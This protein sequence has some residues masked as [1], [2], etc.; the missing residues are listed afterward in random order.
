MT[1]D[2]DGAH[3]RDRTADHPTGRTSE[4]EPERTLRGRFRRVVPSVVR[5]NYA[6]RLVV[7]LA[8]VA[9][10]VSAAG[11]AG[12]VQVRNAVEDDRTEMLTEA[13]TLR[14]SSLGEWQSGVRA[15]TRSFSGTLALVDGNGTSVRQSLGRFAATSSANVVEI[16]Y[17]DG[18]GA[19]AVVAA[20]TE[21][22][23]AERSTASMRPAWR[24]AVREARA[25]TDP[26]AVA[27]SAAYER[28]GGQ[29][30]AF[31]SPVADRD[32]VLLVVG[33]VD[34]RRLDSG[35]TGTTAVLDGAGD[36]VFPT[37]ARDT[38]RYAARAGSETARGGETATGEAGDEMLAYAP[39]DGT[40]WVV[41]TAADRATLFGPS[42]VVGRT[43]AAVIALAF[44]SLGVAALVV[45][46]ETVTPLVRLRERIESIEDGDLGADLSTEREDEIGR[47]YDA[48]ADARDALAEQ[49][50][51]AREAREMAEQSKRELERQN[52]RLDQFA[53]TLSHDLRNPLTVARGHLELLSA[54]LT[55]LDG[56]TNRAEL[57]THVEKVEGAHDRIESIIDD[58]LTL[59]REGE[60][61]EQTAEVALDDVARDAWRNVDSGGATLEITGTRSIRADRSRLL[62]GLENLFRNSIDHVGGDVTVA[63]GLL[64]DGFYVADDGPGIPESQLGDVFEYGHTT[65]EDGTGLGLSIVKT[66]AE[67]HG[68][69]LYVDSTYE[70]G[71]MFVFSNVTG[72]D[73]LD[74]S[75][76][77]FER[78]DVE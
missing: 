9:L 56:E 46:R 18:S 21:Q 72:G 77:E 61:I 51:Q 65:S 32:A 76:S 34:G 29:A 30:M 28:D 44:L 11:L 59:T 41:V 12:Y 38:E 49:I 2:D 33:T 53:S 26:T 20:S 3:S 25:S 57:R 7:T 36:P 48:V 13:A 19:Q 74:W 66:I 4:P 54:Q 47:L 68:W 58:V 70:D 27:S 5:R 75:D 15:Q 71:A 14:A 55:T 16:H 45:S 64:S 42:R 31:A 67:A 52:D 17:V 40:P 10:L 69:R 37:A 22:S 63:V 60:S 39:V 24:P 6:A 62:R 8:V 35:A 43:L 23:A 78:V 1:G 73:E 50:R